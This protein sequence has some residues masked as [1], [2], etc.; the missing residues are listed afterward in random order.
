MPDDLMASD[1]KVLRNSATVRLHSLKKR[2]DLNGRQ[3]T[4]V[5]Y[6][7]KRG[8]WAVE[9]EGEETPVM[10]LES[11]LELFSDV[12][13]V[14]EVTQPD[15]AEVTAEAAVARVD[16]DGAAKLAAA[17]KMAAVKAHMEAAA[18]QMHSESAAAAAQEEE[19]AVVSAAQPVADEDAAA[20]TMPSDAADEAAT[21]GANSGEWSRPF[22]DE[23]AEDEA[24]NLDPSVIRESYVAAVHRVV[25]S[26]AV[27]FARA[28]SR[29]LLV[30]KQEEANMNIVHV[31]GAR[32]KM[33]AIVE[34]LLKALKLDGCCRPPMP[35][36]TGVPK[37]AT[38]TTVLGLGP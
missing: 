28:A 1:S 38:P 32:I 30:A 2:D 15:G 10:L 29:E 22:G 18:A 24:T 12:A 14:E 11:N 17:E 16:D 21:A 31:L 8:R 26:D 36:K 19:E 6:V 4:L 34:W 5:R 27:A 35:D 9:V 20:T 13:L 3:G 23:R 33:G 37:P 25:K 7:E